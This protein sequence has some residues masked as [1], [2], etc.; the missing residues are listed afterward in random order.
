TVV[1][2]ADAGAYFDTTTSASAAYKYGRTGTPAERLKEIA[3]AKTVGVNYN[4]TYSYDQSKLKA[5]GDRLEEEAKVDFKQSGYEIHGDYVTIY[6]GKEGYAFTGTPISEQIIKEFEFDNPKRIV[7]STTITKPDEINLGAI[8]AAVDK[9]AIDATFEIEADTHTFKFTD[10]KHGVVFDIEK[11]KKVIGGQQ[12]KTFSIYFDLVKPK[13]IRADL[14]K[15]LF[16]D[17]LSETSTKLDP[18]NKPRTSN[19]RLACEL[20][21]GTI[22]LSGEEFSYN[23]IVGERTYER[24][25]KDAKI[26]AAGEVIDGVGGGICQVSSTIYMAAIRADLEITS[27]RHHR[28]EVTYAPKG[29]DATIVY[30]AVD[31][32]FINNTDYPIK[33]LT[34]QHG[35]QVDCTIIGYANGINKEVKTET[36]VYDYSAFGVVEEPDESIE[37]G[38]RKLKNGGFNGFKSETYRVVY[39]DG[40]E[41][42]RKLENKSTYTRLDKTYLV[43]PDDYAK[44][45]AGE[46][47]PP[48]ETPPTETPSTEKPPEENSGGSQGGTTDVP[49][50]EPDNGSDPEEEETDISKPPEWLLT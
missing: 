49:D 35:D 21:N 22:L 36:S 32:K 47:T 40:V 7:L 18:G 15:T 8:K 19:V 9:P 26:Y 33:I 11:A 5:I 6:T 30:G 20:I 10:E 3:K 50:T 48:A 28:F 4:M 34:E 37:P 23:K 41:V 46:Q 14:E 13:V 44:K 2:S 12:D 16:T 17:T 24:G 1:T 43:N 39:I 42:S 29:E 45:Q 27:R 38:K 25:F 31:F